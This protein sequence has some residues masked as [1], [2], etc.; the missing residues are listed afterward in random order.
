MQI[1]I[2]L[3]GLMI[4]AFI[5]F[6]IKKNDSNRLIELSARNRSLEDI[7]NLSEQQLNDLKSKQDEYFERIT[8]LE[9][10]KS[11]LSTEIID[12]MKAS[13]QLLICM[14]FLLVPE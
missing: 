11:A 5:V 4:G 8:A 12:L 10:E 7:K 13:R 9:K 6:L 3:V 14:E 2:F 1:L